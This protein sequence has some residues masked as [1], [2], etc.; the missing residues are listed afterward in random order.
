MGSPLDGTVRQVVESAHIFKI[1]W[2]I[3]NPMIRVYS[4]ELRGQPRLLQASVHRESVLVRK[5][6]NLSDILVPKKEK[7]YE[8]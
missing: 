5:H 8:P 1:G 7:I 4:P 3:R 6:I 2:V